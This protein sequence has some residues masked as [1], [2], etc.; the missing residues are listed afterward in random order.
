MDHLEIAALKEQIRELESRARTLENENKN[1]MQINI[2]DCETDL[3]VRKLAA[4]VLSE[5]E[6]WG[7]TFYVPTLED[8]VEN[9]LK[10]IK[11]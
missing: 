1:L 11:L 3:N 10:K 7:D 8:I 5:R 4:Q 9:I 2:D 6:I